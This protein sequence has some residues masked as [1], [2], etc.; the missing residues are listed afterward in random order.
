MNVPIH[1][2]LLDILHGV[3]NDCTSCPV[4]RAITRRVRPLTSV[5]VSATTIIFDGFVVRKIPPEVV[6]WITTYDSLPGTTDM[7]VRTLNFTPHAQ[8]L[9]LNNPIAKCSFELSIP[10]ELVR[11]P[12]PTLRHCI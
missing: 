9:L 5:E 10:T 2:T 6:A 11:N 1:I 3:Q 12:H 7:G 8:R 4:A